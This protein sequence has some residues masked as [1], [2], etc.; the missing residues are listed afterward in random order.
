[1]RRR[2]K[3]PRE[4]TTAADDGDGSTTLTVGNGEEDI[5]DDCLNCNDPACRRNTVSF[6]PSPR[7][8]VGRVVWLLHD[9][10]SEWFQGYVLL[11]GQR[12]WGLLAVV[13]E[14]DE[15]LQCTDG[16]YRQVQITV[17]QPST[18]HTE[19]YKK[20]DLGVVEWTGGDM[21]RL[22]SANVKMQPDS[23]VTGKKAASLV[24]ELFKGFW[25]QL[26]ATCSDQFSANGLGNTEIIDPL[27][28]IPDVAVIYGSFE[29]VLNAESD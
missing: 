22:E 28:L 24:T 10:E 20:V 11:P 16:G 1:M 13:Q 18:A 2:N 23:V 9:V 21:M 12:P 19:G 4:S 7:S 25:K 26:R 3:R 5:E 27:E 29:F 6:L 14:L 17:Q 15:C 8:F